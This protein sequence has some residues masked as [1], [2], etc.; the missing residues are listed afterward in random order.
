MST[1]PIARWKKERNEHHQEGTTSTNPCPTWSP[2]QNGGREGFAKCA[3]HILHSH[4]SA[5]TDQPAKLLSHRSVQPTSYTPMFARP[6][7]SPP[8]FRPTAAWDE[9]IGGLSPCPH[10]LSRFQHHQGGG[11]TTHPGPTWSP[12]KNGTREGF[13]TVCN[14]HHVC[15]PPDQSAKLSSHRSGQPTSY[16]PMFARPLTSPPNFRPTAPGTKGLADSRPAH[17]CCPASSIIRGAV[18]PPILA[19]HGRLLKMGRARVSPQCATH[20]IRSHASVLTDQPAKLLSHR[21]PWDER[22]GGLSPCPHMPPRFQHQQRALQP[23]RHARHGR[24]LKMGRARVSP[25]PW[26]ERIGGLSLCPHLLSR[27]QHHQGGATATHPRP[28]CMSANNE[29]RGGFRHARP[30]SYTSTCASPLSNPPNV[31]PTATQGVGGVSGMETR[32]SVEL[33]NHTH[34]HTHTQTKIYSRYHRSDDERGAESAESVVWSR[35]SRPRSKTHKKLWEFAHLRC[36]LRGGV[37]GTASGE[38]FSSSETH[39]NAVSRP[40]AR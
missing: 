7:T 8:N 13:A 36:R 26:D 17:T 27:F 38:C 24:L 11:T 23:P 22:I 21:H 30:A 39:E 5:P 6:L 32:E 28:T 31:C 18:Q 35:R 34:T 15:A 20:I 33:Q 1:G 10:L 19:R 12:V 14:P 37:I 4:A 9:R 3:T 16:T 29:A 40:S 25:H 2:V